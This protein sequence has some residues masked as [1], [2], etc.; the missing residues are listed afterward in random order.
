MRY[1]LVSYIKK[2]NGQIDEAVSL[3]KSLKKNDYQTSNIIM[4]FK[5][6]KVITCTVDGSRVDTDW[7]KLY[8]YYNQHYPN[9]IE[10]LVS[11]ASQ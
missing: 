1:F 7:D 8:A 3:T 10:R 9:V 2:P 4:D 5:E 6:K 11:E